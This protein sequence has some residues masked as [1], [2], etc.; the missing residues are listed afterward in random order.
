M[1]GHT[2]EEGNMRA[3]VR[4]S[5]PQYYTAELYDAHSTLV[6]QCNHQ[7]LARE[8]ASVC[9]KAAKDYRKGGEAST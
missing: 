6:F 5:R 7:H 1:Q 2:R 4:Q 8:D 9:A 3:A